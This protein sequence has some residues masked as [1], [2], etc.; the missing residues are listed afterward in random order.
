MFSTMVFTASAQ[1][2]N[3][4]ST[5]QVWEPPKNFV[6]PVTLKIEELKLHGLTDD[7]ITAKLTELGMGWDPK[8]GAKWLGRALTSE[9]LANMP[10]RMSAK[11]PSELKTNIDGYTALLQSDR[12][13]IMRTDAASWTGVSSEVVSGSMGISSGQTLYHYLCVQLGRLDDASNWVETVLTHNLGEA[14]TWCTYDNDEGYWIIFMNKNTAITA[15][16]NYTIMLDGTQDQY[17]WNYDV[18]INYQWART[19]HLSNLYNQCGF[20][21]EVYSNSGTYTS[22]T[23]HSVFYRNWLHNAQGWPYWTNS[24]NT[25]WSRVDPVQ[26][27]HAMGALSYRWETWV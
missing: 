17:G 20:Q 2:N 7:Q 19:G 26:E 23:Y 12:K 6:N 10:N 21:K 9:E 13:S 16:D 1:V 5:S 25:W 14:Y 18:W 11:S 15:A 27:S 4:F 3:S 22:D 8:T 24:V